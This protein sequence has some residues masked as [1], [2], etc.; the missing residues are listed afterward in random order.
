[1]VT[2]GEKRSHE[3]ERKHGKVHRVTFREQRDTIILESQK[4]KE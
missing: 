2:I 1:M 3:F 4:V